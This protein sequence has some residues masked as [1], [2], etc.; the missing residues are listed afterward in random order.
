M[1][2]LFDVG[3]RQRLVGLLT[4]HVLAFWFMTFTEMF[5]LG[6]LSQSVGKVSRDN[7]RG[8]EALSSPGQR[9]NFMW[10]EGEDSVRPMLPNAG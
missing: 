9:A 1:C 4:H 6:M 5:E 3:V 7:E 8:P 2:Y 10:V